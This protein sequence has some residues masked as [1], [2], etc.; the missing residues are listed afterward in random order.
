LDIA[1]I[2]PPSL[3]AER[4]ESLAYLYQ[5]ADTAVDTFTEASG[6]SCPHACGDCCEG[7]V[8]DIMPIEAAFIAAFLA[9][10]DSDRAY[11]LAASGLSPRIREDGRHGCPLHADDTPY[12]CTVYK[13][14]PLV[15]RMF[16]FS[17]TRDKRGDAAYSVCRLGVGAPGARSASGARLLEVFGASPPVMADLGSEL[18]A[19]DPG[20]ASGRAPLPEALARALGHVLFLVGMKDCA[21]PDADTPDG[22]LLEVSAD[23]DSTVPRAG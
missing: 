20:S 10:T 9:G 6:V 21:S 19:I 17:A 1:G 11:D 15:C 23:E 12:H 13:A 7:F 2:L 4:L 5:R 8:P 16:A 18:V 22:S 14:R 3:L